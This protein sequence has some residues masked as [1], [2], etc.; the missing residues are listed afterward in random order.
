MGSAPLDRELL[1]RGCLPSARALG[2]EDDEAKGKVRPEETVVSVERGTS[3]IQHNRLLQD[4]SR[5]RGGFAK[6]RV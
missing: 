1:H 4:V 5:D 6:V 2:P 3:G